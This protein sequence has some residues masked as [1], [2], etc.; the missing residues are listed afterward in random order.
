M[1]R[2]ESRLQHR[3]AVVLQD[4]YSYWIQKAGFTHPDNPLEFI[5]ACEDS[6]SVQQKKVP[7]LLVQSGL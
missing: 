4:F 7:A 2:N 5:G 1:S 6:R 3:Y